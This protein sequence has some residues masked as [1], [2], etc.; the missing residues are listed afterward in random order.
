MKPVDDLR[1]F[2]LG[3]WFLERA[4]YD[5]RLDKNGYL[6]GTGVFVPEGD[7]LVYRE[8]GRLT[9]GVYDD[10]VS[11][12]YLYSFAG[13]GVAQVYFADGRPFHELD[14]HAGEAAV[15]HVCGDDT[16]AGVIRAESPDCWTASWTIG[17]PRK[18]I[19]ISSRYCRAVTATQAP[20]Q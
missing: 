11:R 8:S 1:S 2:L 16:Y 7:G 19:Q 4:L 12:E 10:H 9:F 14:L 17:G 20:F 5:S 15:R 3:K 13:P 6:E 18:S